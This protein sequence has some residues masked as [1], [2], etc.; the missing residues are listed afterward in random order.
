M[1]SRDNGKSWEAYISENQNSFPGTLTVKVA[2]KDDQAIKAIDY[3]PTATYSQAGT[4]VRHNG[5]Y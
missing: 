4:V 3:D 5:Y 1:I 2:K